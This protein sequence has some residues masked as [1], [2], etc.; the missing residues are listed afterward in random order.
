M[1]LI[2][3]LDGTL[4][5]AK[6][7][8]LLA[9]LRLFAEL[10]IPAPDDNE[11]LKNAGRGA[12]EMLLNVLPD[13]VDPSSVMPRYY[14]Q[15]RAAVL[16]RGELFPGVREALE[17]LYA[18]RHTLVVC[19]NS[20]EEYL[21]LVLEHTGISGLLKH[22]C[23]TEGYPSKAAAIRDILRQ[24]TRMDAIV[25][26]DTHRDVEAAHENSLKAIAVTYGYGNQSLLANADYFAST[27][28]DVVSAV[29]DALG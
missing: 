2:F 7:V 29:A 12:I 21:E 13:G 27:P 25:I 5:Q 18:E 28:A 14:K 23:S 9:V 10:G 16:E 22:F 24:F 17:L 11:I 6:P 3:D 1:L 20:P 26:G 15:V 19:T 4:F 8:V